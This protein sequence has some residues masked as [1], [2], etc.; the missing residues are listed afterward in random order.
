MWTEVTGMRDIIVDRLARDAVFG[1][2]DK[3]A[4]CKAASRLDLTKGLCPM[5]AP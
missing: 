3:A 2:F 5:A 4:A 1:G